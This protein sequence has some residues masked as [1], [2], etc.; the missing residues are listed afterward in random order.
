MP[1]ALWVPAPQL[2]VQSLV[3]RREG[4]E[5]HGLHVVEGALDFVDHAERAR[6]RLVGAPEQ[7]DLAIDVVHDLLPLVRRQT[8]PVQA[9]QI[10]GDGT[11]L[12]QD[13]GACR[14]G[15]VRGEHQLD[16]HAVQRRG[17]GLRRHVRR[18]QLLQRG[19]QREGLGLR[20]ALEGVGAAAAH[21]MLLLRQ[22][23][24]PEVGGEGAHEHTLLPWRQ[25][26]QQ[27]TELIVE[28]WRIGGPQAL[29]AG[30]H[31]LFEIKEPGP[32]GGR[33]DTA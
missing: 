12:G 8:L 15:R 3:D 33:D 14:F 9:L 24:E 28:P 21:A 5:E 29:G 27:G 4:V 25:A 13:G 16:A 18:R 31:A 32:L 10:G 26:V 19:G 7:E 11:V 23:D 17:D 22:V 30:A 20:P 2:V 6:P 1:R